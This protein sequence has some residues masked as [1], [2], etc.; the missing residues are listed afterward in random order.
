MTKTEKI[1]IAIIL[2]SLGVAARLLPHWWNFTP[3]AAIAIFSGLYLG[4]RYAIILPLVAM[5][6]G[7]IF[8]GFYAAP[9]MIAV[10]GCLILA[11]LIGVVVRKT[12]TAETVI[13]G[14]IIAST[15]FF[16]VTNFVVWQYSA[17]YEKS[18]SGLLNCYLMA[19][20][21]FRNTLLGDL[22]Y[23]AVLVGSYEVVK[24]VLSKRVIVSQTN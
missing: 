1:I 21:F 10:Y 15:V 24:I 6:I 11:G 8:I 9:L 12:K 18:F 20:P 7:D 14:S 4:S 22:F 16:I 5:V 13:A 23:V 2:I 19:L 3:L 17:W